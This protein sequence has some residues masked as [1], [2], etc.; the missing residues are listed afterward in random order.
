MKVFKVLCVDTVT[1]CQILVENCSY[2][3]ACYWLEFQGLINPNN[4]K[5]KC[6]L[7]TNRYLILDGN[8]LFIYDENR[9][10]LL[11]D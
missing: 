5:I 10:L 8:T 11:S 2:N 9:G 7:K 4:V 3:S 1:H 6:D